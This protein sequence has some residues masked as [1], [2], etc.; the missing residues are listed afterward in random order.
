M[1]FYHGYKEYFGLNK[2]EIHFCDEYNFQG[3][4]YVFCDDG[5]PLWECPN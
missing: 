4:L 5:Q 1:R 3:H 2:L